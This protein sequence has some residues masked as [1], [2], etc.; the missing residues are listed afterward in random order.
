M[1]GPVKIL[2]LTIILALC[3]PAV[4]VRALGSC[5]QQPEE[6][7]A[8]FPLMESVSE[9]D[10]VLSGACLLILMEENGCVRFS[11]QDIA[12]T[13]PAESLYKLDISPEDSLRISILQQ[14]DL[15]FVFSI[16]I[17]D[18]P[19][20]H[21]DDM[22]IMFPCPAP[23]EGCLLTLTDASADKAYIGDYDSGRGIVSFILPSAGN[24]LLGQTPSPA[25]VPPVPKAESLPLGN[26]TGDI[27]VA[28]AR[29]SAFSRSL[30]A[31]VLI[32]LPV[33]AALLPIL[34]YRQR[35]KT[36]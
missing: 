33:A 26:V 16:W 24:Y 22:V 14:P 13:I 8:S 31:A 20:E 5:I 2:C 23:E 36:P 17:N 29:T 25:V 12:V 34:V 3:I 11:K 10:D 4:S 30:A 1:K 28:A 21:L 6:S 18:T 32:I 19:V 15:S 35:R 27:S 7:G 9:T